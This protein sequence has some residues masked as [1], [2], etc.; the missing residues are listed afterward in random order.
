M[1]TQRMGEE[2][3]RWFLAVVKNVDD[4]RKLG[5]VQ[6]SVIG[7]HDD[8]QNIP[9]DKLPWAIPIVPVTFA[10]N[11]SVGRS[12]TGLQVGSYVF[13]FFADGHEKN[14]PMI[15]GSYN[16]AFSDKGTDN[17]VSPL[18]KGDNNINIKQV[19]PEP[20]PAYNA[21]YP[22][23]HVWQTA[24]GHVFEVDDT[25]NQERIRMYHKSGTY[26]EINHDGQL[27]TK[28][29]DAGYEIVVKDKNVYVGGTCNI[30]VIGD[31]N[32]AAKDL[33]VD[34]TGSIDIAAG[35][36]VS[37]SAA[38]GVNLING[39]DLTVDGAVSCGAGAA[40]GSFN[41]EDNTIDFKNGIITNFY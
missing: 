9:E 25:P 1:T 41:S 20:A 33:S 29:A 22:Y 19:G 17:D 39:T 12:P 27:V 35:G 15:L 38:G 3:F 8:A 11:K 18:A 23:N 13:G 26:V 2:G 32:L 31:C 6:I 10:S 37:I 34:V 36:S 21:K 30:E 7:E 14:L 28:V 4:P 24:A 5:M 16:K 40:S